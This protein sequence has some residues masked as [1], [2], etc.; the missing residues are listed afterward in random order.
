M[1]AK[2]AKILALALFGLTLLWY[3]ALVLQYRTHGAI[4]DDPATYV[5]MALDLAQRGTLTHAF[6]LFNNLFDKGLS[7]DAFI[8]PGYHIVRETGLIAPNFAFGFPLLLALGYHIFGESGLYRMTPLMGLLSLLLTFALAL[9]FWRDLFPA[10]RYWIGVL[11]VLLLATT[12]KQIQLALVPMSDVPTQMFC[13]LAM[14]SALRAFRSSNQSSMWSAFL[15]AALCG[16]SLGFAYLIRHSALVMFI[17]LSMV[18]IWH[19][20]DER[21]SLRGAGF[22]MRSTASLQSLVVLIGIALLSFTLTILPDLFYRTGTLGSPFAIESPESTQI[23]WL[24]AP[25][26]IVQ[27]FTALFSV[28]GFGPILLVLLVG[29]SWKQKEERFAIVV[30]SAWI[31]AF[32]LFHAPLQLTGVFENNL[33]YLLPAYPAIALL[34]GRAMLAIFDLAIHAVRAWLARGLPQSSSTRS[35]IA[36]HAVLVAALLFLLA[37]RALVSPERFAL[38]S[39]GWMS[40]TARADLDA[41]AQSLPRDA[42]LGVSDQMAGAAT[43]YANSEIFRPAGLVEPAREFPLLLQE[44]RT[45]NRDVYLLGDWNCSPLAN[46]SESLPDW[47]QEYGATDTEF[48]IRDLPYE[49]VQKLYEIK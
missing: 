3:V 29:V 43:L 31:L 25:R 38:R 6:P 12:P 2:L 41:L 1:V 9:E 18:A 26:Q 34:V 19:F 36:L 35:M 47:L 22:E 4:G 24:D 21:L 42:V 16:I 17:P 11:A 30:L 7:W 44:L 33:R 40:A 20:R 48:E 5:Q 15:F 37:I 46:A 8:T 10:R 45:A 27:T 13:L 49:C 32:I 28:T 39:Y 23:L 14:W